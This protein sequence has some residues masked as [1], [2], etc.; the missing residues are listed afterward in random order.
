LQDIL[1]GLKDPNQGRRRVALNRLEKA[2]PDQR[3]PE[4]LRALQAMDLEQD[5][6]LKHLFIRVAAQWGAKDSV[7]MLLPYIADPDF[8]TRHVTMEEMAKLKDL[9]AA[10]PVAARLPEQID[11][12][13]AAITLRALGP[14]AEKAVLKYITHTDLFVR[15][16]VCRILK[17]IGTQQSIPA[18]KTA[19]RDPN[20]LVQNAAKEALVEVSLR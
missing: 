8:G 1:A 15:C 11:R 2:L 18:L 4:V 14:G 12:G 17:D 20:G 10:E 9:R 13:R 16:E 3:G 7:P 5:K 6:A 19:A